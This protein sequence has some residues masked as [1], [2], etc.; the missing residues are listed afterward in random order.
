MQMLAAGGMT[1][2]SDGRREADDSNPRGYFEYQRVKNLKAD[3]AWLGEAQGKAVKIIVQLMPYVP[4]GYRY[5]VVVVE[6]DLDEV[7]A[8]QRAMLGARG[9][10]GCPD[11]RRTAQAGVCDAKFSCAPLDAKSG[12]Y[13]RPHGPP[14]PAH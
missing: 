10:V 4:P 3:N 13:R 9:S 8:S 5:R 11:L 1:V 7:V 14:P 6:R 2:L 12:W